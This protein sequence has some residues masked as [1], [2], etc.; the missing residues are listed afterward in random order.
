MHVL[1]EFDYLFGYLVDVGNLVDVG[2][3]LI[4]D[5]VDSLIAVLAGFDDVF[6][7]KGV[8]V[9]GDGPVPEFRFL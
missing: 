7:F 1:F 4:L 2:V 8:G 9:F 3:G 6:K 5:G